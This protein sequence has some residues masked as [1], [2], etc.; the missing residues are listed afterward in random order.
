MGL[1]RTVRS[2]REIADFPDLSGSECAQHLRDHGDS[3]CAETLVYLLREFERLAVFKLFEACGRLLVGKLQPDGRYAAG[4]CEGVIINAARSFGF[5]WNDD[6]RKEFRGR[7]HTRMWEAIRAGRARKPFWEERFSRALRQLAIDVGRSMRAE[8]EAHGIDDFAEDAGV[9]CDPPDSDGEEVWVAK[10]AADELCDAIRR[11][12]EMERRVMWMHWV[13][14]LPIT[15][16]EGPSIVSVLGISD[17]M[18][19]RYERAAK[20][21][22]ANDPAVLAIRD[23]QW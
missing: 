11:L 6:L 14:D 12:P 7:C 4:H 23:S 2:S 19:R 8:M 16:S 5:S 13:E 22:L 21:R 1:N 17:S 10:M 3:L 15:D 20:K 9:A 18:V